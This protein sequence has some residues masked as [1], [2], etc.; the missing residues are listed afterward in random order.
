MPDEARR[1]HPWQTHRWQNALR[2]CFASAWA[3]LA[4]TALNIVTDVSL[5]IPAGGLATCGT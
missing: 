5:R 4:V 1:S 2:K 3:R